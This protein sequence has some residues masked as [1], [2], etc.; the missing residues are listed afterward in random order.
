VADALL[1][2]FQAQRETFFTVKA[3]GALVVNQV[4]FPTQ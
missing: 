2:F 1:A 3:F 4:A